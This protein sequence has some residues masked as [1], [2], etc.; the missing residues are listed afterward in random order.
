MLKSKSK[1]DLI[2]DKE[3]NMAIATEQWKA[4]MAWKLKAQRLERLIKDMEETESVSDSCA[5][6]INEYRK[7]V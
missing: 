2:V 6:L 7:E 4:K 1:Y 3:R 5:Y